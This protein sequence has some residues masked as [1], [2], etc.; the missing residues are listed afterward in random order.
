MILNFVQFEYL[1]V[2]LVVILPTLAITFF[3][4]KN[5]FRTKLS[6]IF[7]AILVSALIFLVWDIYA[8]FYN[9]WQ[10]NKQFLIGFEFLGLPF[11]EFLFFF[12]VPFSCLFAWNEFRSFKNWSDF[13]LRL[14]GD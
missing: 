12:T 8:T 7:I 11:E 5:N 3:H 10:F 6:S 4:P 1:I 2:N 14:K 13:V 9:H